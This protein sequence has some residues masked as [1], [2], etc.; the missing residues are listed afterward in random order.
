MNLA[1]RE[2]RGV[3]IRFTLLTTLERTYMNSDAN[4]FHIASE[5]QG[6]ETVV[7]LAGSITIDSSPELR[8][9]L[10]RM[11][12]TPGCRQFRLDFSE[13]VYID[14][15]GLAVLIEVLRSARQL[16]KSVQLSGLRERPRY[17]LKSS[18]VLR[19]FEEAPAKP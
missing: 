10:L 14:S 16:D 9:A 8:R 1:D 13:I 17:L 12:K 6:E 4:A 2:P 3:A 18:G 11:L 19:L 5:Q 7:K 15:S